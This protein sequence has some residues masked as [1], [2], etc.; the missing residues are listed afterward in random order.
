MQNQIIVMY[1]TFID[2]DL[3]EDGLLNLKNLSNHDFMWRDFI[4]ALLICQQS[5]PISL[6]RANCLLHVSIL[7]LQSNEYFK[8]CWR[9][10]KDD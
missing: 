8:I 9:L 2:E 4:E 7:D 3:N 10:R 6:L 5:C 1:Y